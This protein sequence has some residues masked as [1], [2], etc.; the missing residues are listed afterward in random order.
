MAPAIQ[1][2]SAGTGLTFEFDAQ[3]HERGGGEAVR[4]DDFNLIASIV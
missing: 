1:A 2:P 4:I 3:D